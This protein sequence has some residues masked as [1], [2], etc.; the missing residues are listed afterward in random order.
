[1]S[2][3]LRLSKPAS[4]F[5][6]KHPKEKKKF[7]GIFREIANN[8]DE[9]IKQYDIKQMKGSTIETYRLRVGKYRVIYRLYNDILVFTF[10]YS[11]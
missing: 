11:S 8:Y 10:E 9:A 3:E 5:L 7:V 6:A 2:Y 4:K 1:M